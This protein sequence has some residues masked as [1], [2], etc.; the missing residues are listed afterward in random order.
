MKRLS[1]VLLTAL[2]VVIGATRLIRA[3]VGTPPRADVCRSS[4]DEFTVTFSTDHSTA[5]VAIVGPAAEGNQLNCRRAGTNGDL[6]CTSNLRDAGF[7]VNVSGRNHTAEFFSISF[8]G[9]KKLPNLICN[10]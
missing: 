7:V 3:G 4:D 6:S 9:A 2:A 5:R 1:G 8:A 10:F